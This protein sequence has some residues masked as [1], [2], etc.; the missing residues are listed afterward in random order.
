MNRL[1]GEHWNFLE[2][3]DSKRQLLFRKLSCKHS[4]V[5]VCESN[6]NRRLATN[7]GRSQY[8]Y[9]A[10]AR[11]GQSWKTDY[12]RDIGPCYDKSIE[13]Q[14]GLLS[15]NL[16]KRLLVSFQVRQIKT[17][18]SFQTAAIILGL[19]RG[20]SKFRNLLKLLCHICV[21]PFVSCQSRWSITF[22]NWRVGPKLAEQ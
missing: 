13:Y 14:Y 5:A 20:L 1:L 2:V 9:Q 19:E 21:S 7:K 16:I 10:R 4:G 8:I 22:T 3:L 17:F 11:R 6:N 18:C 15:I 12:K